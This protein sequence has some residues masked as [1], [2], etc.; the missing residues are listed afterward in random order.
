MSRDIDRLRDTWRTLGEEDPLWAILSSPDK[1]GGRWA[2]DEFFA[3]GENEIGA[4]DGYCTAIDR[5][6]QRRL[7]LD[8]G[9]GVGRLS[10]ALSTRY[11]QVIGIDIASTMI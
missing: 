7:A 2:L 5:P 4:I 3:A 11:A 9:C 1:R 10:R 8:F 6:Q